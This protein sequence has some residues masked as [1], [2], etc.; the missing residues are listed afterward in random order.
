MNRVIGIAYTTET[1]EMNR[2]EGM[3][4]SYDCVV[5]GGGPAG[6]SA[7]TI[8]AEGGHSTLLIEREAMPRFHVGESLMPETFW[9]LER[10][11]V[12]DRIRHQGWQVKK[13]VQFVTHRGT[14]SDPFFFQAA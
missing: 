13:S 5:I 3:K 2:S 8:V 10:L 11:G 7:A 12:N 6:A 4:D 14:E 1:I 9:A